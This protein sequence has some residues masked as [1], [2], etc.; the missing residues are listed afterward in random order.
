MTEIPVHVLLSI[1]EER[2]SRF[3]SALRESLSPQVISLP[4]A[5][6]IARDAL[7]RF[8]LD[9]LITESEVA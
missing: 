2:A 6:A 7:S 3:E 9:R 1:A 8:S 4:E 5:Q